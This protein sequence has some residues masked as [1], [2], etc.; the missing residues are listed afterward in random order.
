MPNQI[1]NKTSMQSL[2]KEVWTLADV[3]A[4]TGVGFTDCITQLTCL[5]EIGILLGMHRLEK[6]HHTALT[7]HPVRDASLCK[8]LRTN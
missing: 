4:A 8:N 5:K 1:N 3:I 7:L 6:R 2:T